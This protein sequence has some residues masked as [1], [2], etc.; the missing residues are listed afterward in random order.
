MPILYIFWNVTS[1]LLDLY[2]LTL[3]KTVF[4]KSLFLVCRVLYDDK[5]TDI[6]NKC[7]IDTSER[8][9]FKRIRGK[10]KYKLLKNML[11]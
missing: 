1:C 10:E 4:Q 11:K 6:V 3:F 8:N 9:P 7:V 5:L 2:L